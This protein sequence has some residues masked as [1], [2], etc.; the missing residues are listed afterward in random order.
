MYLVDRGAAKL[1]KQEEF[2]GTSLAQMLNS[3][4]ISD[5]VVQSMSKAAKDAAHAEA[6]ITVAN[7]CQGLV[8]L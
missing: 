7:V 6:T 2:N 3:L 8:R 1:I 4:F 5:K